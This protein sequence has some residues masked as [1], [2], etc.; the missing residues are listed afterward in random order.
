MFLPVVGHRERQEVAAAESFLEEHA[1]T[2]ADQL[3]MRDDCNP[4]TQ[5]IGFIH[6]MRR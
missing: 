4:I 2:T 1:R 3:A 5:H 6:E